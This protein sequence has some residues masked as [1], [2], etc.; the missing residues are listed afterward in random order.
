MNIL[1]AQRDAKGNL[2]FSSHILSNWYQTVSLS[3]HL[4]KCNFVVLRIKINTL[5][6]ERTPA[7]PALLKK[8]RLHIGLLS[9]IFSFRSVSTFL[10]SRE[11]IPTKMKFLVLPCKGLFTRNVLSPFLS[12]F[13]GSFFGMCSNILSSEKRRQNG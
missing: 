10:L 2:L 12:P 1:E 5:N 4:L 3:H 13:N 7:K 8:F 6:M 9:V 11:H